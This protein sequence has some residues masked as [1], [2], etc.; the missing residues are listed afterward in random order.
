MAITP[1]RPST[2]PLSALLRDWP[3]GGGRSGD[4][5]RT[6]ETDVMETENEIRVTAEVPGLQPEDINLD[7]ENNVLTISGE[8]REEH[9]EEKLGTC[10][11]VAS[12][13]VK[14]PPLATRRK[15]TPPPRQPRGSS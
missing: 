12:T 13:R 15:D 8:K 10:S 7:L 3:F 5:M 4:L 9:T 11:A 1:Y 6:P 2:D 14:E